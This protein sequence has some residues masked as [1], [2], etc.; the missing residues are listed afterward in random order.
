MSGSI[1]DKY[2]PRVVDAAK[3]PDE[4][5]LDNLGAFGLL[6]GVKERSLM[7]ECRH[8]NGNSNALNYSSL[9]YASFDPSVGI[10]LQFGGVK[11][12]ISGD[13]LN[14]EVRPNARLYES[15][16]RHRVPWIKEANRDELESTPVGSVLIDAITIEG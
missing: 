12:L 10:T 6:R 8:A 1:L 7:L 3:K 2:A 9:H 5:T 15:L 13:H 11:V 16:L 4:E 14:T